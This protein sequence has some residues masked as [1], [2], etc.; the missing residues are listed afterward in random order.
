MN[1]SA[2]GSSWHKIGFLRWQVREDKIASLVRKDSRRK[3]LLPND[4]GHGNRNPVNANLALGLSANENP[5]IL[6]M[7]TRNSGSTLKRN[8]LFS[9]IVGPL[10]VSRELVI[11]KIRQRQRIISFALHVIKPFHS[12]SCSYVA[13]PNLLSLFYRCCR[14]LWK[15][16]CSG[17]VCLKPLLMARPILELL[18]SEISYHT[19]LKSCFLAYYEPLRAL[20]LPAL[21]SWVKAKSKRYFVM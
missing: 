19:S 15:D 13:F 6:K 7:T 1:F 11:S 16:G 18:S 3:V 10:P 17:I 14:S 21:P 9:S 4:E 20:Q 5:T 12:L 2:P 8:R